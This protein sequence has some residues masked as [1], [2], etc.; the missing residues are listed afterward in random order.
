MVYC[1]ALSRLLYWLFLRFSL[2]GAHLLCSVHTSSSIPS[3]RTIVAAA[4][5]VKCMTP[6]R[7]RNSA[8]KDLPNTEYQIW[9]MQT[10]MHPDAD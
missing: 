8:K 6:T 2:D 5:H 10:D 1:S 7:Q 9:D 3:T 4:I